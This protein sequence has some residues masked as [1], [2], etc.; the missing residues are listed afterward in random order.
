MRFPSRVFLTTTILLVGCS[1]ATGGLR[2][3]QSLIG[4]PCAAGGGHGWHDLYSC[5]FGPEGKASCAAQGTCHGTSSSQGARLSGGFV[6]G[7]SKDSCWAGLAV[8]NDPTL[9]QFYAALRKTDGTGTMP[10]S[11][12]FTFQPDDLARIRAWIQ[13]GAQN[14]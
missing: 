5:Y 6:C 11:S 9:T 4:D 7:P 1:D 12:S 3:G 8:F 10:K 2:G 13:Q 14:D